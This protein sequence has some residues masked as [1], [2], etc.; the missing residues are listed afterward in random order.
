MIYLCKFAIST[1]GI[2]IEYSHSLTSHWFTS[3]EERFG[4]FGS[5]TCFF[6][7]IGIR[8][9]ECSNFFVFES[10]DLIFGW[11]YGQVGNVHFW[12]KSHALGNIRSN[13]NTTIRF[14]F[15]DSNHKSVGSF[16]LLIF[17]IYSYFWVYFRYMYRTDNLTR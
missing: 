16:F 15:H 4:V 13:R 14:V 2:R 12:A 7:R 1:S 10:Y 17:R 11:I 6:F 8:S 9:L 5:V 3:C